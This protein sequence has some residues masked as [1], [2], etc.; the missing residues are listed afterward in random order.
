MSNQESE[1]PSPQQQTGANT[2]NT[3][4]TQPGDVATPQVTGQD[5]DPEE[6][7]T[8]PVGE[9]T[10]GDD[11]ATPGDEGQELPPN[12]VQQPTP[13]GSDYAQEGGPTVDDQL[14]NVARNQEVAEDTEARFDDS[15]D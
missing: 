2:E 3:E 9:Q 15:S 13:A 7:A 14:P 8:T 1:Q 10:D 11:T 12:E 4:E 6:V 5:L